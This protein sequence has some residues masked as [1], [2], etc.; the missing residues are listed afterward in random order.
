MKKVLIISIIL[1]FWSIGYAKKSKFPCLISGTWK[2]TNSS[3]LNEFQQLYKITPKVPF[4]SEF[5]VFGGNNEF[6]HNFVSENGTV[7]KTLNG[8]W[9]INA[10]KIKITYTDID[11]ELFVNYFFLDKD[12][13]LG[14]NFSHVIFTRDN[15][16]EL[17]ISLK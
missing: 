6:S 8:K 3:I 1:M 16:D 10:D 15:I 12:L 14:Q 13:V 11:F 7:I 2:Y 9:K 5:L 4:Q 17:K